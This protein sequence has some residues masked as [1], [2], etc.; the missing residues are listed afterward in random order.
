M[1]QIRNPAKKL[2]KPSNPP[3]ERDEIMLTSPELD[4]SPD[5]IASV[6]LLE[7]TTEVRN[8]Y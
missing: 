4:H 5:G 8:D 2:L 7:V 6:C 1:F 3:V